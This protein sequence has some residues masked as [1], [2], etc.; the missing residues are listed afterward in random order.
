MHIAPHFVPW[1]ADVSDGIPAD[2]EARYRTEEIYPHL[3]LLEA[4]GTVI[5]RIKGY[6]ETDE[7]ARLIEAAAAKRKR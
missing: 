5:A 2:L 6:V 3:I 1:R 7:L 4:D